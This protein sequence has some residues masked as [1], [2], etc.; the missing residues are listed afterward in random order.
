MCME[1]EGHMRRPS[2]LHHRPM[3]RDPVTDQ[4]QGC[5]PPFGPVDPILP[6][7]WENPCTIFSFGANEKRK[8]ALT[9][10]NSVG[11]SVRLGWL[12]Q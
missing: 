7:P 9:S 5:L 2:R 12:D 4:P 6:A 1:E 3:L 8:K 10:P 11:Y